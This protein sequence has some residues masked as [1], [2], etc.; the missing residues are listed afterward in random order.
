M[1]IPFIAYLATALVIGVSVPS[2]ALAQT[3][4]VDAS[5]AV[6]TFRPL[7][8]LGSTVDRVPSNATDTFFRP[9][10]IKQILEAGWGEISYR[11]NTDLFVQAWHWNPNGKWSDPSGKGYFVGDATPTA[12]QIRHS[13]GYS[14]PHRG[15]TRNNGTEFDGY[16][17]L[18]D[19]DANSYWKS[20]PYLTQPFTHESDSLHPQWVIVDLGSA[21]QVSAIRIVWADPYA[22]RYRVQ[23]WKGGDAMD[24][25]ASGMW[26]T[27]GFGDVVDGK[28]GAATLVDMA[29]PVATRYVR[30]LMTQSSNTCDTHGSAD[31]RNCLGYAIREIYVG[32]M[33]HSGQLTDYLHHSPDQKQTLTYCS[34]VDPWHDKSDLYVAP[35]RM[36][37]GD[38]PGLDLFFTSGIT[39]GLPAVIPIAMLYSTPEDAA[40]EIAYV[41][42]RRYPI[43][44]IEMGEEPDGQYTTPEDD[45]ALYLQ[46]ATALHRVDPK[47]RLGGPVFEG[48]D[49]DIKSWADGRGR[50]SWFGRFLDYLRSHGRISDLAFMSFEHYPFDGCETPW[51]N[52]YKEPRLLT[53]IMDVWRSDG[54]PPSVPLLDTE[55]N[56][57]G[58]E[59]AVDIFGALWLGDTFGAFL[60]AGGR[61][62]F[63]YHDLPYS[64]AHPACAN[65]WGTYHMFM[66]NKNYEIRSRTSQFYAAQ[67]LTQQWVVPG[68][69]EHG[70]F[71]AASDV[72]DAAGN[73]LVTAYAVQRPDGQWSV[74]LINKDH[75]HA[76]SVR[77]IFQAG[78]AR[79]FAGKVTLL[80]F[81]KAQYV[82]HPNRKLGY[83]DPDLP[84]VE[85]KISARPAT[86]Y[87][88][89]AASINILRGR[90]ETSTK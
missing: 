81:G 34:S 66:V 83:A 20:N 43:R 44:Y 71:K 5:R 1:K 87:V 72:K 59:A 11:Q 80:S 22:I 40:A 12:A 55:T 36:E 10:Q 74:L 2:A 63:Y 70:V 35:D 8:A 50:T 51:N 31:R 14:L 47:L 21:K 82:W 73:T 45:A 41:E 56:A 60:T 7:E 76:H 32:L 33:N 17:R 75:D 13:Y 28:G 19:G 84:P 64:P 16:S 24:Q 4:R 62:T 30:V 3:V 6:N 42:K 78:H 61:A 54:I 52:L 23:Y 39:R 48:V 27:F 77:V 37:S 79:T 25:Q 58:G 89:P 90:L 68:M 46:F 85:S 26:R 53:H 18:D 49:E 86:M 38:Q 69:K 29:H 88:L 67:L 57:H 65:S 15:F 9:D